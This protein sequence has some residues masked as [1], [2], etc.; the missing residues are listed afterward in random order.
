MTFFEIA[1]G[2]DD[3]DYRLSDLRA[4]FGGNVSR[5][6]VL[7]WDKK[8]K[9]M[10]HESRLDKYTHADGEDTDTL[11]AFIDSQK[12]EGI[13][14]GLNK[15]FVVV[16]EQTT[17]G[18]A[19]RKMEETPPCKDI[20]VTKGGKEDEPLTGWISDRRMSKLLEA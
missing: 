6:P 11:K 16:S 20:F 8:P 19:K 17:L 14:Y 10:I 1:K 2:K 18:D 3:A 15:G 7:D 13:E 9:Y 4:K 12:A 5:L